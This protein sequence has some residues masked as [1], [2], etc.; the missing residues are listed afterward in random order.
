MS[1]SLKQC[2]FISDTILHAYSVFVLFECR[3]EQ[4]LITL[5]EAPQY[6]LGWYLERLLPNAF[7]SITHH[8]LSPDSIV[9]TPKSSLNSQTINLYSSNS[10]NN[11]NNNDN[12]NNNNNNNN[13]VALIR[14]RTI[15]TEQPSL[16]GEVSAK[17][18]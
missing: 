3:Q 18:C 12:N 11:N 14:E 13:S 10:S 9:P 5:N 1:D 6:V 7:R 8:S 15:P 17:I 2:A 4:Q 16:V